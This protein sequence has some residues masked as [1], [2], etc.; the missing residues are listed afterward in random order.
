MQCSPYSV[1]RSSTLG[2]LLS[3]APFSYLS[4]PCSWPSS[5]HRLSE[6][7]HALQC[8]ALGTGGCSNW[9]LGSNCI[10]KCGSVP[11]LHEPQSGAAVLNTPVHLT[12]KCTVVGCWPAQFLPLAIQGNLRAPEGVVIPP[13]GCLAWLLPVQAQCKHSQ[14]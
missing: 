10:T 9:C 5:F 2:S 11:L 14:R 12:F 6:Q 3:C 7:S 13:A 4:T 1:G 8:C